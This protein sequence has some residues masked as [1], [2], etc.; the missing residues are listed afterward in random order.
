MTQN[1]IRCKRW[2]S[3]IHQETIWTRL[4]T[5][6][7]DNYKRYYRFLMIPNSRGGSSLRPGELCL[8]SSITLS[9]EA[10]RFFPFINKSVKRVFTEMVD[11]KNK[12][13]I[14]EKTTEKEVLIQ[15]SMGIQTRLIP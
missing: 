14:S 13:K 2:Q 15:N 12:I 11:V 4:N 5:N 8:V 3:N 1:W 6:K 7:N 10:L 9:T